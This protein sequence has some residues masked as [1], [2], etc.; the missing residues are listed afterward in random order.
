MP[1]SSKMDYYRCLKNKL[2]RR[3]DR[4]NQNPVK[5]RIPKCLKSAD[6]KT[7]KPEDFPDANLWKDS[8]YLLLDFITSKVVDNNSAFVHLDSKIL[9]F[10]FGNHYVKFLKI[11]C[12]NEIIVKAK[13][14]KVGAHSNAYTLSKKAEKSRFRWVT[15]SHPKLVD[16]Y[17]TH[18]DPPVSLQTDPPPARWV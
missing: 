11:L 6:I 15:L 3:L 5:C 12:E 7:L 9:K 16:G 1:L 4:I 14:F 13:K 18:I 8:V 10:Y 2:T 17:F